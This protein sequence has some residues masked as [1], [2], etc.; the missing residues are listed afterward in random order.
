MT[1]TLLD[2]H[3]RRVTLVVTVTSI[4]L[5]EDIYSVL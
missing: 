5:L 3:C 1:C 4:G 2:L